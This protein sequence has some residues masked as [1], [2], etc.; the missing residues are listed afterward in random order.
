M[1]NKCK[2]ATVHATYITVVICDTDSTKRQFLERD[3]QTDTQTNIYIYT[4]ALLTH[5]YE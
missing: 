3:R 5:A 2:Y 4:T 1:S